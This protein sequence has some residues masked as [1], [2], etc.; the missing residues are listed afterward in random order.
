[1]SLMNS[2][3]Y[4]KCSSTTRQIVEMIEQNKEEMEKAPLISTTQF[5]NAPI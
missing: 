3:K 1:M 4:E 2:K 5:D